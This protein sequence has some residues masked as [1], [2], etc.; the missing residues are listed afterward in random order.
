MVP[1]STRWLVLVTGGPGAQFSP[2]CLHNVVSWHR[3]QEKV[4]RCPQ[5]QKGRT[6]RSRPPGPIH[7]NKLPLCGHKPAIPQLLPPL[8]PVTTA[9]RPTRTGAA[10]VTLQMAAPSNRGWT[11]P[12]HRPLCITDVG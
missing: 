7:P 8:T 11:T 12:P 4:P 9:G 5:G 6:H 1:L 3:C 10:H 2:V